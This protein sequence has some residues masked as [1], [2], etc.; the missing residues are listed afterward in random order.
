MITNTGKP[1][2]EISGIRKAAVLTVMLGEVASAEVFKQMDEDEVGLIGREIARLTTISSEVAEEVLDE[3]YQMLMAHDYVL[4]GGLDYAKKVLIGAFGPEQAKKLLDRLMKQLGTEAASFDALQK[5]DPQQLAKFIHSEHPQTIALIL[6][7]LNPS[8]AAGLLF[9]LPSELRA[10]VALR[11]A[12]LE[13]ISPDIISKIAGII[14]QKLKALGELSRE[15]YGGVRAVAEMFNRMDS[16]SSKE[17]LDT[18]EQADGN[19]AET[20]RHLMFVF[21]DL[22][23]IDPNGLKEVLSRVD[24]KLLTVALKGTSDQLRNH[25][26]QCMSQRGA[27]ML[28]EDMDSLGPVKIKEVE[29]AQQQIISVVRQLENE[30]VISMKGT[31]GEQYVV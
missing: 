9:S 11:M 21:E 20:I 1:A 18:L 28:R 3:F 13:Q 29:A 14:G 31:V 24:R 12:S 15:S 27:E 17:I 10:D 25:F 5:A 19:L 4:K 26:L 22:L 7:H 8:Q 2:E 16:T 6:S 30:G 23:L